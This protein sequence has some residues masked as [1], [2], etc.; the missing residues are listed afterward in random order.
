MVRRLDNMMVSKQPIWIGQWIDDL[1]RSG[2]SWR[3]VLD[4]MVAWMRSRGSVE[5]LRIVAAAIRQRGSR[6]DLVVFE[7]YEVD[8]KSAERQL[9]EDTEFAVRRR[10]LK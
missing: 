7:E 3:E 2:I 5:A 6:S 10:S 4:T 1:F 8:S 9:I